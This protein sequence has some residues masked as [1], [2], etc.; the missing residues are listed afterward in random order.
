MK[1]CENPLAASIEQM[2]R[3]RTSFTRRSCNVWF[4]RST[5]SFAWGVNAC[6]GATPSRCATRPN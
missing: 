3:S 1:V 5:R 6:I 4:A 2:F